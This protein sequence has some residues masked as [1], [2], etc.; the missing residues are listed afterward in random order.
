MEDTLVSKYNYSMSARWKA[1]E[2]GSAAFAIT[3]VM[4]NKS[5]WNNCFIKFSLNFE[6]LHTWTLFPS[7]CLGNFASRTKLS[8]WKIFDIKSY[9]I[10]ADNRD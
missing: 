7:L 2:A 3:S 8:G 6:R 10:R 4:S 5:V 9:A 1:N